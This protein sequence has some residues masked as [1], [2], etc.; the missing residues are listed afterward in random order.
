MELIILIAYFCH[1]FCI[2]YV[3]FCSPAVS[4]KPVINFISSAPGRHGSQQPCRPVTVRPVSG[5]WRPHPA[6]S[7]VETRDPAV[8]ADQ[9]S[10]LLPPLLLT[11]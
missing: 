5:L 2:E 9:I 1:V 10:K 6:L 7:A 8:E 3:L 11:W 4:A